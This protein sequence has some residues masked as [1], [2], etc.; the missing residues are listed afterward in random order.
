MLRGSKETSFLFQSTK[1]RSNPYTSTNLLKLIAFK[2][3]LPR[4]YLP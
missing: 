3:Q 4:G 1:E 2:N